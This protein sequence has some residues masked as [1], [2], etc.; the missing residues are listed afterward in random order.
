MLICHLLKRYLFRSFAHLKEIGLF[1]YCCFVKVLC[2]LWVQILYQRC[3]LQ[4]SSPSLWL[5][6]SLSCFLDFIYLFL[7][8]GGGR[9][10]NINVWSPLVRPPLGTRPSTQACA[11]TGNQTC[12]P[13]VCRLACNPLSH[14]S[15][16]I[17]SLS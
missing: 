1:F 5:V 15:Q 4:I 9:E 12:D 6:F 8:R 7:E 13:L 10:R 2:I 16:G 11:L 17:F 3:I 14:T